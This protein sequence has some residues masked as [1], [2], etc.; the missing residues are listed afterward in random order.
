MSNTYKE[1]N[2]PSMQF[3][4]DDWLAESG[5]RLCS[6]ES[7]GLWMEMMCI[8]FKAQVRGNLTVN[9]KQ[10]QSK[11]L[12][13]IVGAD[14][15]QVKGCIDELE[16]WNIF[17]RHDDNTIYNRRMYNESI[18]KR[19][20]HEARVEAGRKG[21]KSKIPSKNEAKGASPTPT[22]SSTPTPK[23]NTLVENIN[24]IFD[25]WNS[26]NLIKHQKLTDR[27]RSNI[28][29]RLKD[30][31]VEDIITAIDRYDEVLNNKLYWLDQR[32]TIELFMS[33]KTALP[34][35]MHDYYKT[36]YKKREN[37]YNKQ[38][39]KVEKKKDFKYTNWKEF[40]TL[41]ELTQYYASLM[42]QG[43]HNEY[44]IPKDVR[45]AI[46]EFLWHKPLVTPT[47]DLETKFKELRE[48]L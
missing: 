22:P 4:P 16:K 31:E 8:M 34:T 9:S 20:L 7:R 30:Y 32:W 17:S 39:E 41:S 40:K 5:L 33:R 10:I 27:M 21:G 18:R 46:K 24:R 11:Q 13:K 6:L 23:S 43:L 35:F 37:K 3:Y 42:D 45:E 26:K 48:S 47:E 36:N 1:D 19:K 2:R 14:E 25:F 29:T 28:K 44:N 15:Q 12:A 38:I